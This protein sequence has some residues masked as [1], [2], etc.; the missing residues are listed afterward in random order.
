MT[1]LS[2]AQNFT[3][4]PPSPEYYPP[5]LLDRMRRFDPESYANLAS[6]RPLG[7]FYRGMMVVPAKWNPRRAERRFFVTPYLSRALHYSIGG[8]YNEADAGKY[9]NLVFEYIFP[10]A[11][12]RHGS[13]GNKLAHIPTFAI[14]DER[15]FITRVAIV[16]DYDVSQTDYTP[17]WMKYEQVFDTNGTLI[18][19]S[20]ETA[21]AT[22]Q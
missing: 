16:D 8:I 18:L 5:E 19:P 11:L 12:V 17:R 15:A 7:Y 6:Q 10:S 9:R 4:A 13:G 14:P 22:E 3:P 2:D 1:P 20:S 21:P